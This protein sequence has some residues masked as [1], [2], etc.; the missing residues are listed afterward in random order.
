MLLKVILKDKYTNYES[1]LSE[2][3]LETLFK[4]REMLCLKFAKKSLKLQS[5]KN[6]FPLNKKS[7]CMIKEEEKRL[8]RIMQTQN[9][10]LSHQFHVCKSF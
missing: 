10:I 8:L 3:K 1:A 7:H 2:L 4:R 9:V 6:M 5:F